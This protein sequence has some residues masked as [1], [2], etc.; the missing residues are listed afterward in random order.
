MGVN[1]KYKASVFSSLLSDDATLREFYGAFTGVALPPDMPIEINTLS[2]V[3]YMGQIND[4]SF[5][6]GDRLVIVIEH[7]STINPNMPLRL[8]I[9]V[10]HIYQQIVD[11][12]NLYKSKLEKFLVFC[13]KHLATSLPCLCARFFA[14]K[15]RHKPI[16]PAFCG[17]KSHT[18]PRQ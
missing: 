8:L 10:A 13:P 18:N 14:A 15:P 3:L 9:Y 6:V 5:T 12:R 2:N 7:Q 11:R 16:M 4:V 17:F 1:N